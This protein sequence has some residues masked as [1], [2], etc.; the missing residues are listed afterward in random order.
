MKLAVMGTG[1]VG[2]VTG[3]A[4]A[5]LGHDVAGFDVDGDRIATILDGALPFFEP[6]LDTSIASG[7]SAGRLT[8][9]VDPGAAL[10][11]AE[12]AF[13]CVGT[14]PRGDGEAN[15]AALEAAAELIARHA[16]D[17]IVVVEKSTVPAGTA[18]RLERA[19]RQRRP[20][21]RFDVV[22]NPEFL[23][24]GSALRDSLEPDRIVV[25]LESQTAR[26]AIR[27]LYEPLTSA[28]TTLIETDIATA[29]LS[30]HASNGFLALKISFA[31]GLARL[32]ERVGADVT[33]VTEVMGA[34]SRIGRP[35]LSA[36][37]GYGGS[38]FPKDVAAFERLAARHGYGFGL[39]QEA[40]RLNDEAVE[41]VASKI[42]DAMWNLE[43]K[44]I[45]LLGL[46]FK[47]GT[48]DIRESPALAL[49][50]RLLVSGAEVVGYDPMVSATAADDVPGLRIAAD[51]LSAASHAHCVVLATE[52]PEFVSLDPDA[53]RDRVAYPVIVDGRNALDPRPFVVAG[54][55]VHA[56]GRPSRYPDRAVLAPV[57]GVAEA[58]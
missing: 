26:E 12:V 17:G 11:E 2:L 10:A 20:D 37:L 15:L 9:T 4:L 34:D 23:K 8:F 36:G 13:L 41:S 18:H 46:A 55:T 43:G 14:P 3:A 6:G 54:F 21:L 22:S 40:A 56:V 5:S 1:H 24:E 35:F 50:R 30:K 52:W 31:N 16:R 57:S 39:L 19:L 48:D 32:C 29:E 47:P 27:R 49:A 44:R 58:V 7:L 33:V 45:A 51:A 42:A 25:G 28:G 38:C 53:L